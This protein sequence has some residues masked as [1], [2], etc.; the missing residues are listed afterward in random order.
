[1]VIRLITIDL[2]ERLREIIANRTAGW[3]LVVHPTLCVD[4]GVITSVGCLSAVAAW[5]GWVSR[6]VVNWIRHVLRKDIAHHKSSCIASSAE[7]RKLINSDMAALHRCRLGRAY[8]RHRLR[9]R[10]GT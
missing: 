8:V 3:D 10:V 6:L 4:D 7:L 5:H 2:V 9:R 1:M